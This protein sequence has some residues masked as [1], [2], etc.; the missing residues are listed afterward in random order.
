MSIQLLTDLEGKVGNCPDFRN[1]A[2]YPLFEAV[3]NSIHAIW[4]RNNTHDG[5][6]II[7]INRSPQKNILPDES[8]EEIV[9]FEIE[10]NGIG[11]NDTN[12]KS[13]SISDSTY[14]KNLGCKGIGRFLWLKAFDKV[15][16]DSTYQLE[17]ETY[18]QRHIFFSLTRGIDPTISPAK[19]ETQHTVVKLIG[20]KKTYK[21]L[22]TAYKTTRKIAQRILEHCLSY[23]IT[24]KAPRIIV[25]DS[26]EKY[27]LE[28]MY[29]DIKDTVETEAFQIKNLDFI[30]HHLKLYSTYEKMHNLVLCGN[31]R[32]VKTESINKMLGT[33]GQ[34][35]ENE[36]K[37]VYAVYVTGSYLD[38]N[39]DSSRMSFYIPDDGLY[40]HSDSDYP[41]SL[42]ELRDAVILRS[43]KY[44]A[45]YLEIV[46]KAKAEKLHKF[47]ADENPWYSAVVKYC[48]EVM[49]EFDLNTSDDK[50][51]EV[52]AK[53]RG[54]AEH[55]L[56]VDSSRLLK[57][58]AESIDE[59]KDQYEQISKKIEDF[60]K[61]QLASYMVFR[62][63]IIDLLDKKLQLNKDGKYPNEAIIHDIIF[64]RKATSDNIDYCDHNLW[65]IDERL[66][67]HAFAASD[68]ELKQIT[69]SE[70]ADR[71]DI[72]IFCEID[73]DGIAQT[74]SI[75]ELKKAQRN[76]YQESIVDQLLKIV[77]QL[78]NK[79]IKAPNGRPINTS[80]S[81]RYYCYG[82][83]DLTKSVIEDAENHTLVA[84]KDQ[85]G[86]YGYVSKL[87]A[88]MEILAFDKLI[89][90]V[91]RRHKL[92]FEKLGI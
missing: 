11:F 65:L 55:K 31:G 88:Y 52:L 19:N 33:I 4:E 63:M 17:D 5:Q 47:I 14:K 48:P 61:D 78:D 76:N 58:Q 12:M 7:R 9:G 22:T 30:I 46:E 89:A 49:D 79:Q 13:F 18:K 35:D 34:F 72:I 80:T 21:H 53:H 23:Y 32:D 40:L 1:E 25:E 36:R 86:Y 64:P 54:I 57:T 56:K 66:T 71:P 90:D 29:R 85:R 74:V 83:C 81:T 60:N 39:V 82:I 51:S 73:D 92:F 6:I 84:M 8:R 42:S 70:S 37:F 15:E 20:F 27:D 26:D 41:V 75:I 2:L 38:E 67:F 16:I 77:R 10:D 68:L 24:N 43:K 28:Q 45:P 59:I 50:M 3:I 87:N 62:K 69:D 91:R 44:L